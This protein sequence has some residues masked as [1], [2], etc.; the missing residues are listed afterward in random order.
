MAR[1]L[2]VDDSP[3]EMY[4]LTAMLEKHGHQVLKAENGADGVAL[5]RQEKPDVVL[6]DYS[7]PDI[8]GS[9]VTRWIVRHFPQIRVVG[10]SMNDSAHVVEAMRRAGA[11][12]C[13]S[14]VAPVNDLIAQLRRALLGEPSVPAG[15]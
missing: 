8:D 3:T 13:L 12:S 4:K 15:R 10:C 2:I 14:K 11:R 7:L 5:A 9:E 6:M 1:I